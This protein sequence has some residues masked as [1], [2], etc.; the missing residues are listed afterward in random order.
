MNNNNNN[1][2][3]NNNNNNNT[4]NNN[5]NNNNNDDDDHHHHH[6]GRRRLTCQAYSQRISYH[7]QVTSL[8]YQNQQHY[9]LMQ[10]LNRYMR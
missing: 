9:R 4:N 6:P 7:P 1:N 2:N 3:D 5:N 10:V 8:V